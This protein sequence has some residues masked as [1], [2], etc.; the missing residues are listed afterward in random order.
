MTPAARWP[1]ISVIVPVY[2]DW[3][4]IAGLLEALEQQI[5]QDF[6]LILIDN[7]PLDANPDAGSLLARD[8]QVKLRVVACATPGSY[9]ARNAGARVAEGQILVFTDADCRP[10]PGWLRALSQATARTPKALLAGPVEMRP[11]ALANAYEIF[12]TVR[13]LPQ[14]SFV[15]RGYAVTA[16]L[17]MQKDLFDTM[18]GFD[19]NRFSGGDAEFCRRAGAKGISLHLVPD[20]L[21]YH[22]A[23]NTWDALVTKARRIKGGQVA[24]GPKIRRVIWT[25]RSLCPPV[26]EMLAYVFSPYPLAW[27]LVACRVRVR[28]WGVELRELSR[29]LVQGNPRERR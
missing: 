28:L 20:A 19:E 10:V 4:C 18:G 3:P 25:I 17:A 12:D 26:R 22:P 5:F 6:E 8:V 27:R 1:F 24:S 7:A 16:N 2:R 9:A 14:A 29:L 11:S 21:V 13:G 23:R 15:R